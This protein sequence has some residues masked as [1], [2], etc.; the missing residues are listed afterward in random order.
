MAHDDKPITVGPRQTVLGGTPWTIPNIGVSIDAMMAAYQ[1]YLNRTDKA[2]GVAALRSFQTAGKDMLRGIKALYELMG[3]DLPGAAP[4]IDKG[5]RLKV[6]NSLKGWEPFSGRWL[7]FLQ[8][9]QH[10]SVRCNYLSADPTTKPVEKKI[11]LMQLLYEMHKT[12]GELLELA[13]LQSPEPDKGI[14]Q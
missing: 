11:A 1:Q 6:D 14:M 8:F 3:R 7:S 9:C 2:S 10:F 12:G 13:E 4:S 5:F